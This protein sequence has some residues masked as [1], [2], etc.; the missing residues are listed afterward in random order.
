[1]INATRGLALPS[2][3]D[4]EVV[5][6]EVQPVTIKAKM[7]AKQTIRLTVAGFVRNRD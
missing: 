3:L 2:S 6:D 7:V 1:M 5:F 4:C